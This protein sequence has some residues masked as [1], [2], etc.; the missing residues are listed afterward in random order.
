MNA[1]V[2]VMPQTGVV[3]ILTALGLSVGTFYRNKKAKPPSTGRP[4]PA[5]APE[6]LGRRWRD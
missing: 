1:A 5:R 3:A 6:L 4:T 2:E